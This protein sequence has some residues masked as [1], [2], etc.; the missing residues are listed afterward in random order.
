MLPPSTLLRPA[1]DAD[2]GFAQA[3]YAATR[4]DL[5]LLPLPPAQVEQLIAM[6]QRMHEEGRRAMYP[7]AEVL[8]LEQ[9]GEPAG[10]AVLDTTGTDWRLVDLALLPALRGRGLG[11]ALLA[12]LQARAAAHGARIGLAVLRTNA[13]ALRLYRRA[14]FVIAGGNELQYQMLW[15]AP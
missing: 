15:Q 12:A 1:T 7:N 9:A 11:A 8:V 10:R 14:G 13:P 3:L 5:R 2:A 6:Q 4:D